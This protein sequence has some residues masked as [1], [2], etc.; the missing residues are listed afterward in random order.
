VKTR[1]GQVVTVERPSDLPDA[2]IIEEFREPIVQLSVLCPAVNIG[3]IMQLC[4]DRRGTY[5]RTEYLSK[6]RVQ[7]VY[8]VPMA[9]IL[10]DFYDILKSATRGYGSMDYEMIGFVPGHLVKVRLI[11]AGEDV[12]ALSFICHRDDAERRGRD[13]LKRLRKKIRRH[14]FV[15][16][17]QA[18]IGGKIIARETISA[19]RKN[20]TS[21]CY[22]GDIS[23][24]RKLLEKQKKGKKRMKAV[25]GVEI[26]QD[27]FL[28]VL[29]DVGDDDKKKR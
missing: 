23:R 14:L 17:L 9:E 1:D 11:V 13:I 27:A 26:S 7:L 5:R 15:V 4:L 12:D 21:K 28:S 2:S 22:G 18:A 25:G 10:Y 19:M 3:V 24:K 20:V 8:D 16:A 29:G 6:D